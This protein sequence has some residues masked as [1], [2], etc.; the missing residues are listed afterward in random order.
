MS[1]QRFRRTRWLIDSDIQVRL[2]MKFAICMVCYLFL[3]CL[4]ALVDPLIVMLSGSASEARFA[5]AKADVGVFLDA[6][7]V[8]LAFAIACMILHGILVLHRL[9]G[10]IFR[11]RRGLGAVADR[12]L[13]DGIYLREKDLL[14][15]VVGNYNDSLQTLRLDFQAAREEAQ[16]VFDASHNE[17]VRE[18]AARLTEILNL[19]RLD[20]DEPRS[21]KTE[22]ERPAEESAPA[23]V[24]SSAGKDRLADLP[25]DVEEAQ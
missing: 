6:V 7:L 13:T 4:I 3:F 12:D 22:E 16:A 19:W 17:S 15:A 11:L 5:A 2:T 10:P 18:H 8:P 25:E 23:S 20:P 21:E 1:S 9:A 24:G 14:K